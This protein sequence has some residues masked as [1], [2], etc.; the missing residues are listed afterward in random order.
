MKFRK[1][2]VIIEAQQYRHG[3]SHPLGIC[4]CSTDEFGRELHVHTLKGVL[5]VSENDWIITGIKGEK[6]PCRPDIFEATYE[7]VIEKEQL[8]VD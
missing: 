1:K 4:D 3:I 8:N 2:P 5:R 6:Y 7:A